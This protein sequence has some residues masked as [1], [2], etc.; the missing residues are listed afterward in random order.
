MSAAV[1]TRDDGGKPVIFLIAGEESGDLL[2]G[3]LMR[4]LARRLTDV[5]FIGVGG[6]RMADA[7]LDSIFPIETIQLHGL[8]EVLVRLPDLWRKIRATAAAVVAADP[9]VLVV[10]DSPAFSLRVAKAVRRLNPRIP[11]VDYVSP[12]VWAWAPWRARGMRPFVDHLMAIL[13]FEPDVHRRLGGPPTTYVG[14]PLTER[15]DA[16]RPRPGERAPL[17]VGGSPVLLVLPGSRR[18]EV[19]RLM[20]SFGE[21]VKR[22]VDSAGPVEVVLP[23]VDALADDIREAA[24]GWA[25]PPAIVTGEEAKH[26]AFRRAHAALAASGTVTLELALAGVPMVVAYRVDIFLRAMK[27]LLQA[28]SIVLPNLI[29]DENA[30]PELLDSAATPENLAAALLPLL[31]ESPERARQLAAFDRVAA[32]MQQGEG[33]PSARA[34]DIVLAAMRRRRALGAV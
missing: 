32:L 16:L 23:A 10:I 14:H 29:A 11:I 6:A 18:S 15:L 31:S 17:G 26:V 7:G 13:P 21:A 20:R 9:D 34:A 27:P 30:V 19:R 25:L 8:S 2:G 4:E 3:G 33:T 1:P 28:R 22:V 24:A 5:R 12:S